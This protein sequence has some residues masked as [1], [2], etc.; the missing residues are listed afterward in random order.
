MFGTCIKL[1]EQLHFIVVKLKAYTKNDEYVELL[2]QINLRV[3]FLTESHTEY[4]KHQDEFKSISIKQTQALNQIMNKIL[5][6]KLYIGGDYS[7]PKTLPPFELFEKHKD[8]D[9]Y[10]FG[11]YNAKHSNWNCENRNFL[12]ALS[13]RCNGYE[14][15]K[16]FR[17]PWPL[18]L[19]NLIREV[20]KSKRLTTNGGELKDN[21]EIADQLANY[22]EKH[23]SE[24]VFDACIFVDFKTAFD[25]MWWPALMK[26]LENLDMSVELLGAPQ[27]SVLAALLFRLHIHFLTSYFLQITIHLFADDLTM[28]IKGALETRLSK[29]IEYPEYQAKKVL[30]SLEKFADDHILAMNV[31]KTKLRQEFKL[32]FLGPTNKDNPASQTGGHP[33]LFAF[34]LAIEDINNRT[35]LFP[36]IKLFPIY[37]NTN[38]SVGES[39][40]AAFKQIT[41]HNVTGIVGEF[42][43]LQT[44][45]NSSGSVLN[46]LL[47]A[48]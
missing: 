16:L 35:D 43:S 46:P 21:Q 24:P 4:L 33:A 17:P 22:Y 5:N 44:Q 23:F 41:E 28:I 26:K 32:G 27:G 15:I 13:D 9:I 40:I 47:A 38:S 29:N 25:A 36:H 31:L 18:Y 14:S 19:M 48:E 34:K 11:E 10:L 2:Q 8:K 7:P 42:N 1:T 3:Q 6:E 39:V 30:K 45:V 37:C 20:N 12:S